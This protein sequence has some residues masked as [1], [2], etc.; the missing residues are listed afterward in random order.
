MVK[1]VLVRGIL[2]LLVV[3][4]AGAAYYAVTAVDVNVTVHGCGAVQPP[5][6]LPLTWSTK[7]D[8]G[9]ARVPGWTV[10]VKGSISGSQ[11]TLAI[12]GPLGLSHAFVLGSNVTRVTFDG[13]TLYQSPGVTAVSTSFDLS[14]NPP[15]NLVVDCM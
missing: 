5:F 7:P 2:A 15:H 10:Q 4:G 12:S 13:K 1:M 8:G 9:V 6:T 14:H 11:E 3:V